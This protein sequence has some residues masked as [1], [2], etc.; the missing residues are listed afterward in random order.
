MF[1]TSNLKSL[2][3]WNASDFF[4]R[5]QTQTFLEKSSINEIKY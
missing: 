5:K 2:K 3:A 4:L 1:S